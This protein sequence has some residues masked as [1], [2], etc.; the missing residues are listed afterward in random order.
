MTVVNAETVLKLVLSLFTKNGIPLSQLIS[1]LSDSTNYMR[2]KINGFETKLREKAPHLLDIDGDICHHVH[3]CVSKF[4]KHF[5]NVIE[6]FIDDLHTDCKYS[7]DLR[8]YLEEM[9]TLMSIAF[10]LPPQR[11]AHRWLSIFDVSQKIHGMMKVLQVFYFAWVPAELGQAYL[12]VVT[13]I[14]RSVPIEARKRIYEILGYL[15]KKGLTKEGKERKAR[16][17]LK[18]CS[19]NTTK[20]CCT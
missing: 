14:L 13:A 12:P 19:T 8:G 15:K 17:L 5:D 11:V 3:N 10:Y 1:I 2:G 4:C 7:P 9:C 6:Q 18:S 20:Q 16:G